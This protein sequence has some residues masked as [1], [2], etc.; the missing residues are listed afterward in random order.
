MKNYQLTSGILQ[1]KIS[2]YTED[3]VVLTLNFEFKG[4]KFITLTKDSFNGLDNWV[5]ENYQV[6]K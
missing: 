3:Y 2:R 5:K 4:E 1:A 6:L